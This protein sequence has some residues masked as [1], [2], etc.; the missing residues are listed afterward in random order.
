[1][2]SLSNS[3]AITMACSKDTYDV[4]I[5]GAGPVGLLSAFGLQRMGI[6]TC[7]VGEYTLLDMPKK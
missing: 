7:V 1:V 2:P 5:S 4:L 6:S 3:H